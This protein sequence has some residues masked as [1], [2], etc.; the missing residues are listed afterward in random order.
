M[1]RKYG[2]KVA[3][4]VVYIREAHP[5]DGWQ[6]R[7]NERDGVLFKQPKSLME[8]IKVASSCQ[9]GLKIDMPIIVDKM[10][11]KA[12]KDYAAW[13]DRLYVIDL[14]GK[15]AYKS[16][17]GPRGFKP[18]VAEPVVKKLAARVKDDIKKGPAPAGEENDVKDTPKDDSAK[19]DAPDKKPAAGSDAK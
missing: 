8:R 1:Y 12:E 15:I 4:Y 6:M 2:D 16:G 5:S 3:M 11:N 17:P 14:E 7:K 13:P 19:D 9:A 10:D 18:R